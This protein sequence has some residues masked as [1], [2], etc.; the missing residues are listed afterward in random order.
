M[1]I[2]VFPQVQVHLPPGE[3]DRTTQVVSGWLMD[4]VVTPAGAVKAIVA[5]MSD[6]GKLT[7][8][9]ISRVHYWPEPAP[10]PQVGGVTINPLTT[11]GQ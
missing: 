7:V 10:N 8:V 2:S 9:P 6:S 4:I 11:G 1:D 3:G 5:S